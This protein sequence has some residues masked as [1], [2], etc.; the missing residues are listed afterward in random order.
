M[1]SDDG[2][3]VIQLNINDSPGI[4]P[5]IV[6]RTGFFNIATLNFSYRVRCD[7][8]FYGDSCQH[9]NDCPSGDVCG[10]NGTCIDGQGS[11]SCHCDPGFTGENCEIEIPTET[12][13]Q[14]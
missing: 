11:Y 9:F 14:L 5:K 7:P 6:I 8:R 1:S 13:V 12:E 4:P 2:I 10:L 3:D